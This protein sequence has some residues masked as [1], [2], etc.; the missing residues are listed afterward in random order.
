MSCGPPS[1]PTSS[2]SPRRNDDLNH[3]PRSQLV[4]PN[5]SRS[6]R[7]G[8]GYDVADGRRP[9]AACHTDD[10][11]R[12]VAALRRPGLPAGNSQRLGDAAL[13]STVFRVSEFQPLGRSRSQDPSSITA[14]WPA[15][16]VQDAEH[17]Q[18]LDD[19][20]ARISHTVDAEMNFVRESTRQRAPRAGQMKAII[21]PVS[22]H[23]ER[24]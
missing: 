9:K 18:P 8:H 6:R 3:S 19:A 11:F 21:E 16:L 14:R 2:L 13:W 4:P 7:H 1:A 5:P 10:Y 20:R 23:K 15:T 24:R 17:Q 22:L 12:A